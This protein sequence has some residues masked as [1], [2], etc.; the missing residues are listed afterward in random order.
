MSRRMAFLHLPPIRWLTSFYNP[1]SKYKYK[2]DID[3]KSS[4]P[5]AGLM[6]PDIRLDRKPILDIRDLDTSDFIKYI[7][8]HQNKFPNGPFTVG[9]CCLSYHFPDN[10][11]RVPVG[12]K[13]PIKGQGPVYVRQ[14]NRVNMTLTDTFN[15]VKHGGNVRIHRLIIP[16]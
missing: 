7:N 11:K 5:F 16:V 9:V 12:Y 4:Y 2:F 14:A 6:I 15:I 3:E 10:V 13:P 1:P 8:E